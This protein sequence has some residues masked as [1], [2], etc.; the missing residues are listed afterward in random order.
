M[1]GGRAPDVYVKALQAAVTDAT[2]D[3]T[4]DL[5]MISAG[6]DCLAGDPLGEFT[7]EIEHIT[8]LTQWLVVMANRW[9][10]GRVI[11]ALEGGYVPERV[12]AASIATMRAL[13]P[14]D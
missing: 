11:A 3:F 13:L 14:Q 1:P 5:V 6:F 12:G 2:N 4:P 9:C 7:L 8:Q 10:N